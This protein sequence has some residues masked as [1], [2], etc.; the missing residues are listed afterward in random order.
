[1][2]IIQFISINIGKYRF[3]QRR[4]PHLWPYL[5][6]MQVEVKLEKLF[7][8]NDTKGIVLE[9]CVSNVCIRKYIACYFTE[10]TVCLANKLDLKLSLIL[11][12]V[13]NS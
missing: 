11:E 1:M 8:I 5:L 9:I 13:R 10:K 7:H 6:I 12:L 4:I 2:K 3:N